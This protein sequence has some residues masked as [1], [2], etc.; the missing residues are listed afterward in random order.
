MLHRNNILETIIVIQDKI[1]KQE[2]GKWVVNFNFPQNARNAVLNK[3]ICK[4]KLTNLPEDCILLKLNLTKVADLRE[5]ELNGIYYH[6]GLICF[7]YIENGSTERSHIDYVPMKNEEHHNS[8]TFSRCTRIPNISLIN[9][10]L[11][12]YMHLVCIGVIKTLLRPWLCI[13]VY[14][15]DKLKNLNFITV[16]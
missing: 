16:N 4:V 8:L 11:M 10:F 2:L 14:L 13:C 7:P 3:I 9:I 15:V 1:V 5:I 6:L 12:G